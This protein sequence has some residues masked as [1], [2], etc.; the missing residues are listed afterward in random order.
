M[1]PL[2][3]NIAGDLR[4]K[5]RWCYESDRWPAVV[6]TLLTDGTPAMIL[7]RLMQWA[8]RWRLTPLEMLFNKLNAV[9]CHCIIGRGAE[10]GPGFVLI[11]SS[12]VVIN[13]RVRGG[14]DVR[15]EHQVTIGAERRQAP[16]LGDDVFIGAG[17][18]VIGPVEIGDGA[19]VGAN[20]VVVDHV[21]PH[22]TVVGIP[23]RVVRRRAPES[24]AEEN[25]APAPRP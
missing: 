21:P 18:K 17:A 1:S 2:F 24:Q 9:C 15:L 10:F 7:Y 4:A 13:G 11:H 16:K 6:K 5:A 12:G 19:R 22:S 3:V 14:R 8:R 20:A 25:G 23:A